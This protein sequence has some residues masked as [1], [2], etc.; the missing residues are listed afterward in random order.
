MSPAIILLIAEALLKYGPAMA[1]QYHALFSKT[2]P[3][4]AAE[5]EA[6][7]TTAE[8]SYEEYVRAAAPPPSAGS[9]T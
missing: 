3:P 4:T 7:F 6:L 8:K 9:S 2:T 5:W 1:R